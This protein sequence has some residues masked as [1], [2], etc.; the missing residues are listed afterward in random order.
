MGWANLQFDAPWKDAEDSRPCAG[1]LGVVGTGS[2]F[3]RLVQAGRNCSSARRLLGTVSPTV[4]KKAWEQFG[5]TAFY[6]LVGIVGTGVLHVALLYALQHCT[7]ASIHS[8]P[9]SVQFPTW[10][11]R[12]PVS[13]LNTPNPSPSPA[14]PTTVRASA[15]LAS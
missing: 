15:R 8:L 6:N 4:K 13:V 5:A 2:H 9:G 12:A 1:T 10:E 11:V 7:G 3:W 14:C